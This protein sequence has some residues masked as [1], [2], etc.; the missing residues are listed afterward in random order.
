MT[1]TGNAFSFPWEVSLMQWLQSVIPARV[2]S[3]FSFLSA[4]GDET[5]MILVFGFLYWSLDKKLAKKMGLVILMGLCLSSMLKNVFLRRRP[6]FDHDEI[7]IHRMVDREADLYDAAAQGYSFPSIHSANAVGL[8]CHLPL[9]IRKK[10]TLILAA[11][12]PLLVGISRV[13]VGAHYPTD[14][15]AGW[16][17]GLCSLFLVTGLQRRV[18]S[19]AVLYTLL[20]ITVLPGFLFCRSTDFFSSA[21]LLI[22]YIAGTLLEEK[23]VRFEN[24]RNPVRMILRLAGGIALYAALNTLFKLPFSK[25]FLNSGT[26]PALLVR[27][28]RYA[29]I[30]VIEFAV[31]PMLFRYTARFGPAE[32]S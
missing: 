8:F 13:V 24:T 19:K 10:R 29:V 6:Y 32:K 21:G 18:K 2:I 22:G 20:L 9:L 30:S 1:L 28:T 3:V 5:F 4:F 17:I 15:L 7:K 31:Y 27:C 16:A 25:E 26:Y 12:M 23:A 14:V 11:L